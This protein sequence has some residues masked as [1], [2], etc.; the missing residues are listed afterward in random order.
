MFIVE[1]LFHPT[2]PTSFGI[3]GP[4][5]KTFSLMDLPHAEN[6]APEK[7]VEILPFSRIRREEFHLVRRQ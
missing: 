7:P 4:I 1:N 3:I 2:V 5:A 6:C